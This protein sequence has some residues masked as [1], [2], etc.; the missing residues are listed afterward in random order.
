MNPPETYEFNISF[1]YCIA[2]YAEYEPLP[3]T[4]GDVV[5][6]AERPWYQWPESNRHA[7]KGNGF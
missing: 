1:L 3:K 4:K 7:F 5:D 6:V 2:S